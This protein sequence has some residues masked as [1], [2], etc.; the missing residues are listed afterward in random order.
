MLRVKREKVKKSAGLPS[1][2]FCYF[3]LLLKEEIKSIQLS[4]SLT[5]FLLCPLSLSFAHSKNF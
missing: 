3:S 5:L 4:L 1:I 2:Y